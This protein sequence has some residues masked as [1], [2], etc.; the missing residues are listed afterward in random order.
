MKLMQDAKQLFQSNLDLIEKLTGFICRQ[1][2]LYGEDAE[3]FASIV[4]LRLME[5][6]YA[7]L[8]KFKGESSLKTYLNSVIFRYYLDYRNKRWGRWRTSAKAKNLGTP[9]VLLERLVYREKYSLDQAVEVLH[10]NYDVRLSDRELRQLFDQI[11]QPNAITLV[12]EPH[13]DQVQ[14]HQPDQAEQLLS[15]EQASRKADLFDHLEQAKQTLDEEER[16]ILHMHFAK[17]ISIASIARSLNCNQRRLYRRVEKVLKKLAKALK[18]QGLGV[19]QVR[20]LL[21]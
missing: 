7:P 8:A 13:L 14:H 11:P 17:D 9:A 20:E 12:E 2:H 5:G 6:N 3:D 10:T 19:Q 18:K 21:Q 1:Q 4:T 16:Y 15:A